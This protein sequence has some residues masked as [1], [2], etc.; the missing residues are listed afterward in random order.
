M[1]SVNVYEAKTQLSRLLRRVRAGEEIII[2]DAGRPVARL[3]PLASAAGP[4]RLGGD[5]QAVWIADDFDAPLSD[6]VIAA[7]HGEAP[8]PGKVARRTGDKR[9]RR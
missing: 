4:R 9:R 5:E 1:S 6:E 2:A 7:F 8:A 3:V